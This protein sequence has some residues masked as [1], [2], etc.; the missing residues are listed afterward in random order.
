LKQKKQRAVQDQACHSYITVPPELHRHDVGLGLGDPEEGGLGQLEV[1]PGEVAP[2]ADLVGGAH[3]GRAV[4]RGGDHH[5][6]AAPEAPPDVVDAP[7]IVAAAA[8]AA[9]PEQRRA[10]PRRV[11]P[12]SEDVQVAVPTRAATCR[13][14]CIEQDDQPALTKLKQGW[15]PYIFFPQSCFTKQLLQEYSPWLG[16]KQ[17]WEITA[18][19]VLPLRLINRM[20]QSIRFAKKKEFAK[21]FIQFNGPQLQL[22]QKGKDWT[23]SAFGIENVLLFLLAVKQDS[24]SALLHK[25]S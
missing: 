12:V 1:L 8:G 18:L 2:A 19:A 7:E 16:D 9:A 5:R 11:P 25:P 13:N 14:D 23:E 20:C 3:V 24:I 15:M 21:A 4:V 22:S 10:Q 6:R 17:C